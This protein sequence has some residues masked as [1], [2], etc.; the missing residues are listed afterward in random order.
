[1]KKAFILITLLGLLLASIFRVPM[2]VT[3]KKEERYH[4]VQEI[5]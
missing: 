3:T 4:Y 1:M 2:R 5:N